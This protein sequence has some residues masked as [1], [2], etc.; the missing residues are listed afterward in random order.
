[1]SQNQNENKSQGLSSPSLSLLMNTLQ[2][3]NKSSKTM[4]H[5][6]NIRLDAIKAMRR[7]GREAEQELLGSGFHSVNKIHKSKKTYTRKKK[8]KNKE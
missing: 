3:Q 8:H 6:K 1:M 5:S 7:G 4:R 2:L